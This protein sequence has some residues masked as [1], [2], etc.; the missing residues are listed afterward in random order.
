MAAE[1]ETIDRYVAAWLSARGRATTTL[2]RDASPAG[3]DLVIA[4]GGTNP[5]AV[6]Y[7]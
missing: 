3:L 7:P 6:M 2:T 1:R 5:L 4:F